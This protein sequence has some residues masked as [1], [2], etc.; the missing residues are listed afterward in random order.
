M[1]DIF[2]IGELTAFEKSL[3][4]LANDTMP[5]ETKKF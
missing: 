2:E 4:K 1:A 5:K 3:V